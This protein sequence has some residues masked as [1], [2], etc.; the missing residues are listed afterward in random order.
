MTERK[1]RSDATSEEAKAEF[2]KL[3]AQHGTIGD[4]A[5]RSGIGYSTIMRL[6]KTDETFRA[7]N[8]IAQEIYCD[9]LE[10]EAD[11]RAVKG[12][13]KTVFYKGE[14]VGNQTVFSDLLLIFRLKALRPE[15]YRERIDNAVSG[16]VHVT[17]KQ[18]TPQKVEPPKDD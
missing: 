13:K 12:V 15:K 2:V 7:Q 5:K 4:A 6:R 8:D 18:Y 3:L 9:A 10:V 14:D 11:R 1:T 17:V 16:D